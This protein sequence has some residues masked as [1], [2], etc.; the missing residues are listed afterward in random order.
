M[1]SHPLQRHPTALAL[2][3]FLLMAPTAIF[4]GLSFLTYQLGISGLAAAV[5]PVVN[6]ITSSR[7]V[8]LFLLTAPF[9][10]FAVAVLPL[11]SLRV[12]RADGELRV[13]FA[14]RARRLNLAVLA[15][16]VL[17]GGFLAAHML[18]EFLF[19]ART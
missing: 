12:E 3:A 8:D 10:A 9:L 17:L 7:F 5:D 19:E 1:P 15:I 6:S 11:V 4:I 14:F 18:S 16:S 13:T 2:A